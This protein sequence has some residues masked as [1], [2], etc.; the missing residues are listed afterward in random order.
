MA[1]VD[2]APDISVA[3]WFELLIKVLPNSNSVAV[4]LVENEALGAT[5]APD[6]AVFIWSLKLK[7]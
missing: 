3:I 7:F 4:T 1:V 2:K 6:I 5:N